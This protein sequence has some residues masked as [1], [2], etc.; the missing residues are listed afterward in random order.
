MRHMTCH[1]PDLQHFLGLFGLESET[2]HRFTLH[3]PPQTT[4]QPA[5][6][7]VVFCAKEDYVDVLKTYEFD[8]SGISRD[9]KGLEVIKALFGLPQYV[10]SF[11]IT[12]AS[13][14]LPEVTATYEPLESNYTG[15]TDKKFELTEIPS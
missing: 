12:V 10:V 15:V 13:G 5:K 11:T 6:L 9:W 7:A 2:I 1:S 3:V 14:S 8:V 4:K